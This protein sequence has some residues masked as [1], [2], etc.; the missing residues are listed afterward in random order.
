[1]LHPDENGKENDE[2]TV[3]QLD[4]FLFRHREK[5]HYFSTCESQWNLFGLEVVVH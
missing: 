1:M 2:A 5:F 4:I 3:A